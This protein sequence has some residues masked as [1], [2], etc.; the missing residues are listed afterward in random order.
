MT[1]GSALAGPPS[2]VHECVR[3]GRSAQQDEPAKVAICA[4]G[5]RQ[6]DMRS[7]RS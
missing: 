7:S 5:L 3:M 1:H 2:D 6:R 4:A